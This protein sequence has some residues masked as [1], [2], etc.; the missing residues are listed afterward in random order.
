MSC[1]LSISDASRCGTGWYELEADGEGGD[2][3]EVVVLLSVRRSVS[4]RR[5]SPS[6]DVCVFCYRM[7]SY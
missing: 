2:G 5:R 3:A 1:E 6:K 4:K 7:V